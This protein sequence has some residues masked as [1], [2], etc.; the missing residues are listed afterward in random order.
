MFWE[1]SLTGERAKGGGGGWILDHVL[2]I[3]GGFWGGGN[4]D[5]AGGCKHCYRC[6]LGG[7]NRSIYEIESGKKNFFYF[8]IS[9]TRIIQP[10]PLR[11]SASKPPNFHEETGD[12]TYLSVFLK[13]RG[14]KEWIK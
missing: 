14:S 1:I 3:G 6:G 10:N 11:N 12:R 4:G 7:G 9:K 2:I 5:S 8:F 13:P